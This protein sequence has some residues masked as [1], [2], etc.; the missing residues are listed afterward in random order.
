MKREL[1][2]SCGVAI[3]RKQRWTDDFSLRCFIC[4]LTGAMCW[5]FWPQPDPWA[6]T[7]IDHELLMVESLRID[8]EE[9]ADWPTEMVADQTVAVGL[10]GRVR[11]E[12]GTATGAAVYQPNYILVVWTPEADP[13]DQEGPGLSA[14]LVNEHIV[15]P[16]VTVTENADGVTF[17]QVS[18]R[19]GHRSLS[20]KPSPIDATG[21]IHSFAGD[22]RIPKE[23]GRY[24]LFLMVSPSSTNPLGS[25][26]A[27]IFTRR[28]KVTVH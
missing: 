19:S 8:G 7:L 6:N 2:R 17:V 12:E 23:P 28:W 4:L 11:P 26:F 10:T 3:W 14:S 21:S 25:R 18:T 27:E 15:P 22:V 16:P 5:A 20:Q 13:F 9:V 24:D 1:A